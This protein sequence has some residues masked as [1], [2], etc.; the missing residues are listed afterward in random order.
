MTDAEP[1]L[2]ANLPG[3]G[4]RIK[5]Q[6]EDFEVEELPAYSPVGTGPHLYLWLEKRD[7]GA[8]YFLRELAKRLEIRPGDIGTAGM[9]DR[10]AVTR[11]WVSVPESAEARL[12]QLD[13]DNIRVITVSRH[14]NKLRPGHLRGNRFYILVRDV[15]ADAAARAAPI[16]HRL[17]TE[18]LPNYYGEQRF[19]RDGDNAQLGLKLLRGEP[20]GRI[21]PFLRKL[22][23]SAVQSLLFNQCLANRIRDGLMR[24]VLLGDVLSKW[25]AGG[26]FTSTEPQVDQPRLDA[27]ELVIAGPMFGKK[28]FPSAGAVAERETAVLQ[29]SGLSIAMFR[30]F[31]QL[32]EGTRRHYFVYPDDVQCEAVPD[33][34]RLAFSLPAGSYATVMLREVIKASIEAA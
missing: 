7:L 13:C 10:R 22:A 16:L 20:V 1:M 5:V 25:P 18:G 31:G 29:A 32:L 15:F 17:T 8:E 11:Q 9:K 4:G 21:S 33:C 28:T 3:V 30:G 12:P 27:R 24:T 26:M 23:L 19:G 14:G 34:L 2:T 6:L